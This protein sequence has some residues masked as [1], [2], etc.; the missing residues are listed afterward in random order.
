MTEQEKTLQSNEVS[1][2]LAINQYY[3]IH[4]PGL[5]DTAVGVSWVY[6][7]QGVYAINKTFSASLELFCEHQDSPLVNQTHLVIS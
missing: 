3:I 5:V 1:I 4:R 6:W 7:C 2:P